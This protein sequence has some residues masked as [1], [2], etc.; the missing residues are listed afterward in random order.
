[1]NKTFDG[2]SAAIYRVHDNKAQK[3]LERNAFPL[4]N[5][6]YDHND[7]FIQELGLEVLYACYILLSSKISK[8]DTKICTDLTD[9]S[10]KYEDISEI[11]VPILLNGIKYPY[12]VCLFN[13]WCG[14]K[15]I[16]I[17]E[18]TNSDDIL[19]TIF[20]ISKSHVDFNDKVSSLSKKLFWFISTHPTETLTISL[21]E[22]ADL[23]INDNKNLLKKLP[24]NPYIGQHI[25]ETLGDRIYD[26][27]PDHH[28]LKKLTKVKI[29]KDQLLKLI[30][31]VGYIADDENIVSSKAITT[32]LFEGLLPDEFFRNAP[33]TRKGIVD[34]DRATPR[35]GYLER[36]MVVNLS[37]IELDMDDCKTIQGLIVNLFSEN[38]VR[39]LINR[40]Y[41]DGDRW[42]LY[43]PTDI[44]SEIN[45]TRIFRSPMTCANPNFKICKKCFGHYRE[46]KTPY[47]GILA[48]QYI[49][50]RLT[51][52]SLRT[53]HHSG[54]CSLP[55]NPA[56]NNILYK[57]LVNIQNDSKKS[58]IILDTILDNDEIQYFRNI[59]GFQSS[60]QNLKNQTEVIYSNEYN[61]INKDVTE[62]INS[63][64]TLLKTEINL[65]PIDEVY[66]SYV[67]SILSIGQI[68]S[69]YIE[70]VLCNMYLVKG[71]TLLRYAIQSNPGAIPYKKLSIRKLHSIVSKLLGLL[72]EPNQTTICRFSPNDNSTLIESGNSV[73]EKIWFNDLY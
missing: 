14:F 72:Y 73:L 51:Q 13:K 27:I 6:K 62:I 5:I 43:Q 57:H 41:Y 2:D 67:K 18:F 12:G 35:S 19:Q 23:N 26:T 37:P 20:N 33:G 24:E 58:I 63:V 17:S 69:T 56:V 50:E 42:K 8:K 36:S 31:C 9:L 48:G 28:K 11:D 38:H 30:G 54:S 40:Y 45:K 52:L 4:H 70:I 60:Q 39:S 3:E 53:F 21:L 68:Y 46:I 16:L 22:I 64:M 71:D 34:K 61:I 44:K 1:L 10:E 25:Y 32:S 59:K 47:V 49:A 15:S 65:T 66:N 7:N 29:R 55:T